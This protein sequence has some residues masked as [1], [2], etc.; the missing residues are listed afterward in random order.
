MP[1]FSKA[2]IGDKCYQLKWGECEITNISSDGKMVKV[3]GGRAIGWI[4]IDGRE[5]EDDA[6]PLLYHS[7]PTIS[8]P[9]PPKRM[10]K[11]TVWQNWHH[12]GNDIYPTGPIYHNLEEAE[13]CANLISRYIGT[14]STTLEYE[15]E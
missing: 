12:C 13:T 1:D 2:R 14:Y 3:K 11:K 15:E 5:W 6:N 7:R 10:V 4:Y 8:D 9:P